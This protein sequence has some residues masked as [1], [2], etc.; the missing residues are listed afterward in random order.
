MNRGLRGSH[1]SRKRSQWK[2]VAGV[3]TR[4]V[5]VANSL[6][7]FPSESSEKSAVTTSVFRLTRDSGRSGIVRS[8][9]AALLDREP[10]LQREIDYLYATAGIVVMTANVHS[11]HSDE[12]EL[13]TFFR[14][15]KGRTSRSTPYPAS[16]PLPSQRSWGC[17]RSVL[18]APPFT[19]WPHS[20]RV[21]SSRSEFNRSSQLVG[22]VP[23]QSL[24]HQLRAQS[25]NGTSGRAD[26]WGSPRERRSSQPK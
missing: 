20:G 2:C 13:S 10:G 24:L 6:S 21:P 11:S 17:H 8:T 26:E 7:S 16:V 14:N 23:G 19:R 3:I 15:A 25:P 18:P 1:G 4:K 5:Q 12:F 22:L 9:D